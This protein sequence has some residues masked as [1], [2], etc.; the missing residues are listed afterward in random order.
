MDDRRFDNIARRVGGLRSR[1]S[2]LKIAGS[3]T[4]AAVFA[5]LGLENSARAGD[6]GVANH[7]VAQG[8]NC[9]RKKDCCGARKRS[10]EI[11]CDIITGQEGRRCCGRRGASCGDDAQCCE[12]F[13][14]NLI[15]QRCQHI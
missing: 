11:V 4:A 8:A 3:G 12:T 14:C 13:E 6:L 7:C 10:K 2:A 15:T 5:A 1:R 9:S